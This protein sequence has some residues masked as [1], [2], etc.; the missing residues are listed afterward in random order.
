MVEAKEDTLV[1]DGLHELLTQALGAVVDPLLGE[2]LVLQLRL[3]HVPV[4]LAAVPLRIL[5]VEITLVILKVIPRIDIFKQLFLFLLKKFAL[6]LDLLGS[7]F[8]LLLLVLLLAVRA[9]VVL[10]PVLL[11]KRMLANRRSVE[12]VLGVL[13]TP[14]HYLLGEE[15]SDQL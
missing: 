6:A 7:E 9:R 3:I 8:L 4:T 14:V 2:L 10:N 13:S 5:I 11:L 12:N 1:M 15:A